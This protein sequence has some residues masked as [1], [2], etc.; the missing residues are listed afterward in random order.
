LVTH[1]NLNTMKTQ[2]QNPIF[3][4]IE[5][6]STTV[7]TK[8]DIWHKAFV[9]GFNPFT[10]KLIVCDENGNIKYSHAVRNVDGTEMSKRQYEAML[11]VI[12]ETAHRALYEVRNSGISS[13]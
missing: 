13:Y 8:Y 10:N 5:V 7:D 6:K 9:I 12:R 4:G 3:N 1:I 11:H 2:N